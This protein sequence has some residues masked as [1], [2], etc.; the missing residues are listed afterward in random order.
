ME[1]SYM[2]RNKWVRKISFLLFLSVFFLL[3]SNQEVKAQY[4]Q[5]GDIHYNLP[6]FDNKSM[7]YGFFLAGN[8]SNYRLSLSDYFVNDN[9]ITGVSSV[10]QTSFTL[11]FVVNK[12]INDFLDLRLLPSVAFYF[13]NVEFYYQGQEEPEIQA[14]EASMIEFPL[15]LKYKSVRRKNSRMYMVAGIKPSIEVG[16]KKKQKSEEDL[17]TKSMDLSLEIGFGLDNYFE[18]FKFAP[19]IRFSYGLLNMKNNDENEFAYSIDRM[20][21]YAVTFSL[22]FE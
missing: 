22:F 1:Q 10:G 3:N 21:T 13:R 5:G 6:N 7:H 14:S 4:S 17:R 15:L 18:L 19:E 16:A 12:R 11:G 9:S 20:N 8:Y 2:E